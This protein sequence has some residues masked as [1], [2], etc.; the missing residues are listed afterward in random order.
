[1]CTGFWWGN[2]REREYLEDLDVGGRIILTWILKKLGAGMD[3]IDLD[4]YK[5]KLRALVNAV[6]DL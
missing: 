2:L 6:V 4:K 3:W 5:D 1:M